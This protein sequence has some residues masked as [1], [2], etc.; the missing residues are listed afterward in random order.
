[1]IEETLTVRSALNKDHRYVVT[2]E[3]KRLEI[4]DSWD[5][6]PPGDAAVTKELKKSGPTW[7]AQRKKGRKTFS[8]GVW[9]PIKNIEIAKSTVER[10]RS[11]PEYQQRRASDLKR[12]DAK[13]IEYVDEF[14]TAVV[15]HLAFH[16]KYR[17]TAEKM[18]KLITEH[19]T[20]VG[21]GT[22]ARTKRIPLDQRAAAAVN[23]W[24]R[25]QT[26][27]YDNMR[28]ARIKGKRREVRTDLAKQSRALL[29]KYRAGD[30][31]DVENC[32][33]WGSLRSEQ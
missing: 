13:H 32:P 17:V 25:H 33:L 31:I 12:K 7:T 29:D 16:D 9:A 21:S 26:T 15:K 28:I 30:D 6:L 20:P 3:G 2:Q 24:M 10:K 5:L 11:R 1:M 18:A 19:A 27:G 4:P 23:A 8:D 14:N 22:V